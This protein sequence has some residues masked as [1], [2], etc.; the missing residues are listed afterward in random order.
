[1]KLVRSWNQTG[2]K[3]AGEPDVVTEFL[4]PNPTLLWILV[5][6]TYLLI[7][8]LLLNHLDGIPTVI[9]GSIVAGVV[10]SAVSFKLTFT[11][12][13]SPEIVIGF[14]RFFADLF[15]RPSL[16]TQARAVFMGIGLVALCPLYLLFFQP[17]KLAK[18]QGKPCKYQLRNCTKLT[19]W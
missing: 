5:W 15:D 19:L 9:S 7:S 17:T 6:S 18:I 1:M 14:A 16:V 13:D 12:Q 8:R 2:Q 3:F 11:K 10:T 4:L